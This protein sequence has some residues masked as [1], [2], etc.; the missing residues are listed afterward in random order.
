MHA[1]AISSALPPVIGPS[2]GGVV[3]GAKQKRATS[4]DNGTDHHHCFRSVLAPFFGG[5]LLTPRCASLAVQG[6]SFFARP[7]GAWK[8]Y[9]TQL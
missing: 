6:P 9:R 7:R 8:L 4:P 2:D 3:F 1:L 5:N